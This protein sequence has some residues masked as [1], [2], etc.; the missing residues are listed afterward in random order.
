MIPVRMLCEFAY[1]PRL[2]YIEWV[3]GEFDENEHTLEGTRRHS[4]V[5]EGGGKLPEPE[6]DIDKFKAKAVHMS[7]S[8]AGLVTIM[9]I[10]EGSGGTVHP[11]EIKKG[12][13]P[14][15]GVW[16][17]DRV[18]IGAQMIVAR[19]NGYDCGSGYVYY[20]GSNARVEVPFDKE[21]VDDVMFT[22][23][24]MK[25][26]ASSGV[27][28]PPLFDSPK[29]QGC[30]LAGICLPDETL[31]AQG[32]DIDTENVR[33]LYPARDDRSPLVV[34]EQGAYVGKKGD[35]L[36]IKK[37]GDVLGSVR[38][39]DVSSVNIYG[40]AQISTQVMAELM[41]LG[42]PVC[43]FSYGGWFR[44]IARGMAHKN[45]ELRIKQ[46]AAAADPTKSLELARRFTAAKIRNQRTLLMRN[47]E[48]VSEGTLET[49]KDMAQQ[50][51]TCG[52]TESLL[53]LEGNAA[54]AYFSSFQRMIRVGEIE[55]FDFEGRNRRP[56]K[57]PVNALLSFAYA[58]L[59][60][61]LTVIGYYVGFDPM[62]GFYHQ[63]RYGRP[64]LALDIMEEF[65][66]IIADSVAIGLINN[67]E[68]KP[69][70]FKK[71]GAAVAM[72]DD[73]RKSLIRAYERRMN[74]LVTH[75]V[76]GYQVSYRRVL[77]L[78]FRLL[79]RFLTGEIKE[80]IGFTTR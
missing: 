30:S 21:L 65:R 7:S 6:D 67:G 73:A 63:P 74:T 11:V 66:P 34:N 24:R 59:V 14:D 46:Y 2:G 3:Q 23:I 55:G 79:A 50:A 39:L 16:P 36:S 75:P 51:E 31:L 35:E 5:D 61:D 18:Q 13:K 37:K 9:D 15:E 27:P 19:D 70:D 25:E 48:N 57:D 10:L 1:C 64:A 29:C 40:N 17:A 38:V 76:F 20:S 12:K 32:S 45:T 72:N 53:G 52:K 47:G 33:M 58:M 41:D 8:S 54:R 44:G 68:V 28:P 43:F 80:Y 42:I 56:P 60:K 4:S 69:G 71:R 26:A 78:Q 62:L 49:M 22:A 77:E